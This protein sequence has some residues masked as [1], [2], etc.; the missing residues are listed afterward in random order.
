MEP[1]DI[2]NKGILYDIIVNDSLNYLRIMEKNLS[3]YKTKDAGETREIILDIK[4]LEKKIS[5]LTYK[6]KNSCDFDKQYSRM[7][8]KQNEIA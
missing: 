7:L 8:L 4:K 1:L 2:I 3:N 6:S 5:E